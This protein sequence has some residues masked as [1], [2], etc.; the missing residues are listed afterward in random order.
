MADTTLSTERRYP[1][2]TEKP[3][4]ATPRPS[5]PIGTPRGRKKVAIAAAV[6]VLLAGAAY[7]LLRRDSGAPKPAAGPAATAAPG[8]A[9]TVA[10]VVRKDVRPTTTFTGRVQAID[11]VELRARVPG[12]LEKQLFEDG[13]QVQAGQS[14]FIIE[15]A[16]YQAE[17]AKITADLE[18]A[19]ADLRNAKAEFGRQAELNKRGYSTP[20][21]LDEARSKLGL[22][23]GTVD[24]DRAALDQ[25][26]LD[27]SYTDV[28]TPVSGQV[29]QRAY[30]VGN[31]VQPS[32]GTLATVVSRDPIYV[33]FPVTQREL[34]EL[35]RRA[36][37]QGVSARAVTVRLRLADGGMYKETG[38]VDFVDVE[39]N[40]ATDSV[41]V[42]A[43]FA[44]P[45]G[46]LIDGQLVT[47][48]VEASTPA[49][50]I[51]IPQQALQFDQTGYFVLVVD[52]ENRVKVQPVGIGEGH[53]TDLE[54]TSGLK[55]GDRVIVEGIQ[56]VRP[57]QVVTPVE[58]KAATQPQ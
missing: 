53:D 26:K 28:R 29:G 24:K 20:A 45:D 10:T 1:P 25:A 37:E 57:D 33:M 48:V 3:P 22:A 16:P 35:R 32:S 7:G 14:M 47:A 52:P 38:A 2:L 43:K 46:W 50:A 12:Y 58:A 39:V 31:Y 23:Q 21:K 4:P 34:L 13:S 51:L 9:V 6:A 11:K 5:T 44:N 55:E 41:D 30:S 40:Q 27:L 49:P 54:V 56:K 19:E 8:P 42:R 15:Q 17:V 36:E 18:G